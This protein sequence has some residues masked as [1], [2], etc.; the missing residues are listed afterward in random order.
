MKLLYQPL[1]SWAS[2]HYPYWDSG[3]YR[4]LC[5]QAELTLW[6]A[7]QTQPTIIQAYLHLVC[8]GIGQQYITQ[9]SPQPCWHSLLEYWLV[10][11]VP[12][13]LSHCTQP[14]PLLA[15]VWNLG[16]NSRQ[17]PWLEQYLLSRCHALARLESLIADLTAQLQPLL[18][19]P[20]PARCQ[21]PFAVTVL[22]GRQV[23]DYFLPGRLYQAAPN[24]V[25]VEDRR[26]HGIWGLLTLT[27]E[28]IQWVPIAPATP[29][30]VAIETPLESV[31]DI[32]FFMGHI[33]C[34]QQ[35]IAIPDLGPV[36]HS[37]RLPHGP[38]VISV[39][40]SQ[41]LWLLRHHD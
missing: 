33:R 8:E 31:D 27:D 29:R 36:Y 28:P 23:H 34:Q 39:V 5:A 37:L 10:A 19:Q 22:N 32:Q 40:D 18:T 21:P 35:D 38:M 3:L 24:V 1:E 30:P 12:A 20:P 25:V 11:V 9:T 41:R 26:F 6:P 13:Q 14:L 16:E 2:Q 15:T 7:F 17:L 4:R